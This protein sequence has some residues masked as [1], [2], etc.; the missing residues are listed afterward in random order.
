MCT[1]AFTSVPRCLHPDPQHPDPTVPP[2]PGS[3]QLEPKLMSDKEAKDIRR[4]QSNML[5]L[6]SAPAHVD[7]WD[8]V[9]MKNTVPY[10]V[11][12]PERS[13]FR[14]LPAPAKSKVRSDISG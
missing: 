5:G 2:N 12:M 8:G 13:N 4:R 3:S 7:V 1:L 11:K 10:G 6:F 14:D 9:S